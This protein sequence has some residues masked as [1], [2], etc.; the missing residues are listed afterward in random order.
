MKVNVTPSIG[1]VLTAGAPTVGV[2]KTFVLN[3]INVQTSTSKTITSV[4]FFT[5]STIPV[6]TTALMT[7]APIRPSASARSSPTASWQLTLNNLPVSVPTGTDTF[8]A[9]ATDSKNIQSPVVKTTVTVAPSVGTLTTGITSGNTVAPGA[10]VLFTAGQ[11]MTSSG[12]TI[13]SVAFYLDADGNNATFD[14]SID[15]PALGAPNTGVLQPDGTYTFS[16]P[17]PDDT[18]TGQLTFLAVATDG[19]G[20]TGLAG[21]VTVNV[22]V[23]AT[24]T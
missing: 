20:I 5:D 9:I 16:Y 17:I 18:P 23:P 24:G 4:Q 2:N 19:T 3:A 12:R 22:V 10:T 21:N 6:A 7:R 13:T 11:V 1:S 8:F 14:P 15:G